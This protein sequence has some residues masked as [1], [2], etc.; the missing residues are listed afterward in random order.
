MTTSAAV[1]LEYTVT[2]LIEEAYERA[3]Y[4]LQALNVH[5]MRTARRSMN[6]MFSDWANDGLHL[7]A[8]DHKT[9]TMTDGT[10]NYTL[11]AGTI[12]VIDAVLTRSSVDTPMARIGRSDYHNIPN[13]TAE[14]KPDRFWIDR[15]ISLPV[16]YVWQTPEN[17]TDIVDYWRL[18]R[19]YDVTAGTETADLPQ[20]W[21]E[22]MCAGL[23]PRLFMK[24]PLEIR[25]K[26]PRNYDWLMGEGGRALKKARDEDRDRASTHAVPDSYTR[27]I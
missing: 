27:G 10:A 21:W 23:A 15:Q 22:A 1:T 25:E 2:E 19:L 13:K 5:H 8:V 11:P 12:D 4:D 26:F 20:R 17:S 6:L 3:G 9:Q 18:R 7:W 24:L 14:G 16:M